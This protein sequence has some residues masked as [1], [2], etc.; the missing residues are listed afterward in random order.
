MDEVAQGV[1]VGRDM[2][3]Q[4]LAGPAGQRARRGQCGVREVGG[5]DEQ[6]GTELRPAARFLE[7]TGHQADFSLTTRFSRRPMPSISAT[8][9]SPPSR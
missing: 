3:D 4:V 9:V 5:P 2:R 7:R 6:G 1:G 8:T